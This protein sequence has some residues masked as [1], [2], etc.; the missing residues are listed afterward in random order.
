MRGRMLLH[1]EILNM[2][3]TALYPQTP[4]HS[5]GIIIPH[6]K[7]NLAYWLIHTNRR[8][9]LTPP[10]L[11][12]AEKVMQLKTF[13]NSRDM[14]KTF[15]SRTW[16]YSLVVWHLCNWYFLSFISSEPPLSTKTEC[17]L[18]CCIS[19]FGSLPAPTAIHRFTVCL[20]ATS[21]SQSVSFENGDGLCCLKL[22]ACPRWSDAH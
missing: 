15:L 8:H 3:L 19:C 13:L 17:P 21:S 18:S 12:H 14:W 20:C 1:C 6:I 7:L 5:S 22:H 10:L 2:G 4:T 11:T 16:E 9:S